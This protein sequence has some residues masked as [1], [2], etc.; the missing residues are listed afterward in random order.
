MTTSGSSVVVVVDSS[1]EVSVDA[2]AIASKNSS[3]STILFKLVS[4]SVMSSS[5]VKT[6]SPFASALGNNSYKNAA[7]AT[8]K[9]ANSRNDIPPSELVSINLNVTS[10]AIL[11]KSAGSAS[12]ASVVVVVG[13]PTVTRSKG[14]GVS[15]FRSPGSSVTTSGSSVVVVVDDPNSKFSGDPVLL[16]LTVGVTP[17]SE[18]ILQVDWQYMLAVPKPALE[19][20]HEPSANRPWQFLAKLP[21]TLI[22]ATSSSGFDSQAGLQTPHVAGQ[23]CRTMLTK[24]L[25]GKQRP[26]VLASVHD[27]GPCL[28]NAKRTPTSSSGA[29]L[30]AEQAFVILSYEH[31]VTAKHSR[32]VF[33][34]HASPL[35]IV[36]VVVVDV[37]IVFVFVV[38]EDVSVS[39]TV[40]DDSVEVDIVVV[41]TVVVLSVLVVLVL[42]V[43]VEVMVTVVVEVVQLP[44]RTGQPSLKASPKASSI[45]QKSVEN[46]L[47]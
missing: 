32:G 30:H 33:V 14:V 10:A 40:V 37:V 28:L 3:K 6:S 47:Q 2:T 15:P 17:S 35:I 22:M 38:V 26:S 7:S 23:W 5:E 42:D 43:V 31:P 13:A 9:A 21:N 8:R 20:S 41:D 25:S 39:V 34:A 11:I 44:Q 16:G 27:C 24:G 36:V 12:G 18:Q 29:E 4:K 1:C 19:G 46:L 45:S